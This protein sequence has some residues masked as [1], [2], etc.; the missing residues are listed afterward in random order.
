M[1]T[2]VYD[3]TR[4]VGGF[5]TVELMV[6]LVVLAVLASLAGPSMLP[7]MDRWRVRQAVEEMTVTYAFARAEAIRRAG[8]VTVVRSTPG[9]TQCALPASAADWSCGWT[10][11]ADTNNDGALSAGETLRV[12][13]PVRGASVRNVG[14]ASASYTLTRWGEP[15]GGVVGFAI[16]ASRSGS[17]VV[18]AVCA[19]GGGRIRAVQ[20]VATCG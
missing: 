12:S 10:V 15:V 14:D 16:A 18:S 19:G 11:Y 9:S 17:S 13:P 20:G 7:V 3:G 1:R 8:N 4:P 5:T 2:P 6:V